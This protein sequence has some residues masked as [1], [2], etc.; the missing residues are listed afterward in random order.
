MSSR[1]QSLNHAGIYRRADDQLMCINCVWVEEIFKSESEKI[2]AKGCLELKYSLGQLIKSAF[3]GCNGCRLFRQA[4]LLENYSTPSIR[5]FRSLEKESAEIL[6]LHL[7]FYHSPPSHSQHGSRSQEVVWTGNILPFGGKFALEP[8]DKDVS[9]ADDYL[10]EIPADSENLCLYKEARDWLRSC[11]RDH[12]ECASSNPISNPKRLLQII[13]EGLVQLVEAAEMEVVHYCALSY[14]WGSMPDTIDMETKSATEFRTVKRNLS[15]RQQGFPTAALSRSVAD[16]VAITLRLGL[17][18]IWVD[19][20]CIVQDDFAELERESGLMH[21]VYGNAHV[22][23]CASSASS[24]DDGMLHPREPW[25]L[26]IGPYTL[27]GY[28]LRTLSRLPEIVYERSPLSKRGWTL[29][30][31][32]LSNRL[33][34]WSSNHGLLWS[35]NKLTREEGRATPIGD[36]RV[37]RSRNFIKLTQHTTHSSSEPHQEWLK[38]VKT[39]ARRTLSVRSDR[40]R[41]L[42]G[43]AARYGAATN[44]RY[45]CGLWERT[46]AKELLWSVLGWCNHVDLMT[47]VSPSWSWA[48]MPFERPI[49][50]PLGEVKPKIEVVEFLRMPG[51]FE[52][53]AVKVRGRVC[54]IHPASDFSM[55]KQEQ[56]DP[57]G[58]VLDVGIGNFML[59]FVH[60]DHNY[61]GVLDTDDSLPEGNILCL[62]VAREGILLLRPNGPE[63]ET[64]CRIGC[65]S[66]LNKALVHSAAQHRA[67]PD[68]SGLFENAAQIEIWLQ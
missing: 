29:Q 24:S 12:P 19:A 46:F 54:H 37:M 50:F 1:S 47:D 66:N 10:I 42:S 17:R 62:E 11:I 56:D 65:V 38:I 48:K 33:L 34:Y 67:W 57:H 13:S 40:F 61:E 3:D 14:R 35:C 64:Y 25:S 22:T 68:F 39:Y 2:Q 59:C 5:Y 6:S 9:G 15:E 18:Y 55:R 41:A 16:A 60:G 26:P 45:L 32:Q 27:T 7:K 58:Y 44:D 20:A 30:E 51:L 31:E 53:L 36:W 28:R 49:N 4:L 63:K 43:L 8:P 23:L 52:R 21:E